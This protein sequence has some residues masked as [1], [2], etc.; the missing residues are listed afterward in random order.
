M[1][2]SWKLERKKEKKTSAKLDDCI[3][4]ILGASPVRQRENKATLRT[5]LENIKTSKA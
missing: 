1:H 4:P 3:L 2:Q 5:K